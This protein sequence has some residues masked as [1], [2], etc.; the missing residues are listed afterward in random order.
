MLLMCDGYLALLLT[1]TARRRSKLGGRNI[2][3]RQEVLR[4]QTVSSPWSFGETGRA[5]RSAS[6]GTCTAGRY[7]LVSMECPAGTTTAVPCCTLPALARPSMSQRA[8]PACLS[9][10]HCLDRRRLQM[11]TC[12][13]RHV[14]R[15][16]V[17]A[18]WCNRDRAM[19]PVVHRQQH[20]HIDHRDRRGTACHA[21]TCGVGLVWHAGHYCD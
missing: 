12:C 7:M 1:P 9:W 4:T 15:R 5:I 2:V 10:R 17:F 11:M 14:L 13:V 18:S 3:W 8:E 21:E 20:D 6:Y 16:N 19:H